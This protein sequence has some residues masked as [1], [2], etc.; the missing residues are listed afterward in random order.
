MSFWAKPQRELSM[1][2]KASIGWPMISHQSHQERLSGSEIWDERKTQKKTTCHCGT[3]ELELILPNGL[4][5][6]RRCNCSICSR[7]NAV[8][9]SVD[10]E[11]LRIV[12]GHMAITEYTFNT[13]QAKHFFCSKCGIYTHH[14]RRSVPTEYGFN[15]SCIEGIE[16]E[17]YINVAYLDGRNNHPKDT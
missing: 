10:L 3:V 11:N 6:L 7:K 13:H 8:V 12:K 2:S 14:Q 5:N 15:I 17:D 1:R 16:I 9:A 4:E